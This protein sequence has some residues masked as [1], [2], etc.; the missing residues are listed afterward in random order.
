MARFIPWLAPLFL[1]AWSLAWIFTGYF[2]QMPPGNDST[3]YLVMAKSFAIG[4]PFRDL[5]SPLEGAVLVQTPSLFP[6]LLSLYWLYLFPHLLALK[7]IIAVLLSAAQVPIYLWARRL[8]SPIL[9]M[10]VCLAYG[11]HFPFLVQGNSFMTE[12]LFT[13]LLYAGLYFSAQGLESKDPGVGTKWRWLA[14][15]AW[16]F[17]A[18]TRVVGWA[19]FAVFAWLLLRRR[20]WPKLAA[21]MT[22]LATWVFVENLM[23]KAGKAIQ[24]GDDSFTETYPILVQFGKGVR[25]LLENTG[26]MLFGYGTAVHAHLLLPWFYNMAP[27]D[28]IKRMAC[29]AVFLGTLFGFFLIWKRN[30]WTRP[31]LMAAFAANLPTFI[32]FHPHDSFRYMA[33]FFSILAIAFLYPFT[34]LR[35]SLGVWKAAVPAAL[36]AMLLLNQVVHSARFDLQHDLFLDWRDEFIALH[37]SIPQGAGRPAILL[38]PDPYFSFLKTGLP[39]FHLLGRNKL[40]EVL[41]VIP[42]KEAWAICGARNQYLCDDWANQGLEFDPPLA[43]S[44][45]WRMMRV[46]PGGLGHE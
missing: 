38:S 42:G 44:A 37:A 30:A 32:L 21:G 5:S 19:F 20:E 7:I 34:L 10:G 6:L 35:D 22:A 13:P 28:P 26:E 15:A 27:M 17:L 31:W 14:L 46:R 16:V 43:E 23:A 9:A 4:Q 12:C 3:Y 2:P 18:R 36:C 41:R 40:S 1:F 11:A 45:H 8:V 33:P 24:Y 39:A 25:M 29:L